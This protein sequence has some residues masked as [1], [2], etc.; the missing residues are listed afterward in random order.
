VRKSVR[1]SSLVLVSVFGL[2]SCGPAVRQDGASKAEAQAGWS[3][4]SVDQ[5]KS[6]I[7]ARAA[8]GLDRIAFVTDGEPGSPEG[9]ARLTQSALA[10]AEALARGVTDPGK[11]Y[12]LYTVPRPHPD[13]KRGLQIALSSGQLGEW[14]QSLAP[15]DANYRKL[16]ERYLALRQAGATAKPQIA[17]VE[18]PIAP[19]ARNARIPA[20][21]QQ[22]IAYDYLVGPASGDRYTPSM[23]AAVKK[24]QADYGIKPDGV[25]GSDAIAILNLSDAERARAIAVNMERLRWLERNPPQTRI[26]VNLAAARLSYWR[27]GKL[28]DVR[29]V[30]V[31]RPDTATP[32]LGSPIYRLVANPTWTVPRSIQTKEIAPKG[33]AYLQA[34]NMFW[35]DGWIVQGSGPK[36]SLGLVKFDMQNDHAIYLHDTPAKALFSL[37]RRQRSH[38]CVRVQNAAEFAE[39]LAR[40]NGITEQW[41][42]AVA[43]GEESYVPLPK[44]IPVRMLYQTV[45]F[46][47]T[48]D[49]VLRADPYEWNDRVAAKLG[50]SPRAT[51]HL[52]PADNDIGP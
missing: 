8:H 4:E 6:A 24:M 2:S 32:Q 12:D 37:P 52:K 1:L 25:I 46:D 5:L 17:P 35:K 34:N 9:D 39:L 7:Q 44:K 42:K 16:S 48:G 43:S 20:I 31:G 29:P 22:L 23:V 11:L 30:V 15:Q 47:E 18:E 38:G 28:V 13:L 41:Q 49:P 51:F 14:L 21:A 19:G 10:F 45:L 50:F 27:D 36:N 33:A 3:R 40:D 26:D